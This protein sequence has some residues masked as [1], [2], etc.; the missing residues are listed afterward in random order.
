MV[1]D[2]LEHDLA[3]LFGLGI[4][5][6]VLEDCFVVLQSVLPLR[7]LCLTLP[8]CLSG[9]NKG[10]G[11]IVGGSLL[12]F[13]FPRGHCLRK[14]SGRFLE[15]PGLVGRRSRIKLDL[16]STCSSLEFLLKILESRLIIPLL[17]SIDAGRGS[18]KRT[19]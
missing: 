12:D 4:G 19:W 18:L 5:G 10:I 7:E 15:V 11:E 6:S 8:C 14:I 2:Q 9:T 16:R 3:I 17:I 13:T 1:L